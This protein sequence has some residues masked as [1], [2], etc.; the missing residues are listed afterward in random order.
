ALVPGTIYW[1]LLP[2]SHRGGLGDRIATYTGFVFVAFAIGF[3]MIAEVLFWDEF[4]SRFNFIAID[5]LVYTREVA[6][7]IWESYPVGRMLVALVGAALL[8]TWLLRRPL[9]ALPDNLSYLGRACVVAALGAATFVVN[10]TPKSSWTEVSSNAY[11]N[12]LSE[13]GYYS[14][15]RA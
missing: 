3:T 7:N 13:D 15:V 10:D 2:A 14:L 12:E 9:C 6:G 5:Y 8:L 11:A 4:T 1:A